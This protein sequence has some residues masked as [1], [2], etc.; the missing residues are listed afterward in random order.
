MVARR[1]IVLEIS[2]HVKRI[3][4]TFHF[5]VLVHYSVSMPCLNAK[6]GLAENK[7]QIEFCISSEK[8]ANLSAT[9]SP[10]I[11]ESLLFH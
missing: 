6:Y 9:Y 4:H 1:K 8:D 2:R 10:L 5:V 3:S 7:R 11:P